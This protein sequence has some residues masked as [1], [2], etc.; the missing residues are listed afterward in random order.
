M[1][2]DYLLTF[3]GIPFVIDVARVIRLHQPVAEQE[4]ADQLPPRKYQPLVDLVDELDRMIPFRYLQEFGLQSEYPGRNIGAL[5]REER[6]ISQPLSNNLRIGDWYYPPTA[7]RW[8]VFRGLATS[9]QV[10]QMLQQ[11]GGSNA[12]TFVMQANP[13]APNHPDGDS[14]SY[15]L[16]S[17]MYMLPPRPLGEHGGTFD[18]LYLITLVDERYYWQN[19][20]ASIHPNQYSTWEG[21]ISQIANL[22]AVVVSHDPIPVVYGQPE[23]DSQLWTNAENTPALLDAIAFNV[24]MVAVR[25]LN[26]TYRLLTPRRSR[27]IVQQNRGDVNR[28]WRTAG[29]DLFNSGTKLPVGNLGAARNAVVPDFVNV[30]FPKYIRDDDPVPHFVNPRNQNQRPSAWYEESYGDCFVVSVP[31]A[32]GGFRA[33]GQLLSGSQQFSGSL[34]AG[35]VGNSDF[36]IHTTA[37]ALYSGEVFALSGSYP[38]SGCVP[39]NLSGLT[40]LAM[41]LA[42]DHYDGQAASALDEVY[43]GTFAWQPEGIH[44]IVWTC[45]ARIKQGSTRV[46]R[47][48]WNQVISEFQHSFVALSGSTN[49]PKGVGGPSVAQ[50]WKD[51]FSAYSGVINNRSDFVNSGQMYV[52]VQGV[53]HLPTQNRWR[54][55][56]DTENIL[57][58]GT[59]GGVT[60]SGF[61]SGTIQIG[62]VYR[63]IDGTIETSH[64]SSGVL[65]QTTPNAAYGANL[66][67][68][69]KMQFLHQ[70]AWTSG[71]IMETRIIPQTQ[72]V[73]SYSATGM[74]INGLIHYSGQL[75]TY[76]ATR[77]SGTAF[78][79]AENVWIIERNERPLL[80][81]RKYDGQIVG[82]AASGFAAPVYAVNE[83]GIFTIPPCNT[84]VDPLC[85]QFCIEGT[86]I[87]VYICGFGWI[88]L[89]ECPP[90]GS[91]A[92]SVVLCEPGECS[93]CTDPPEK[94]TIT[95][96]G[97][98]GDCDIF[99]AVWE[100]IWTGECIWQAA[101]SLEGGFG[102]VVTLTLDGGGHTLEFVGYNTNNSEISASFDSLAT[103]LPNCCSNLTFLAGA[104]DCTPSQGGDPGD[105]AECN[106]T[107][108]AYEMVITGGTGCY[109]R[110]N[111]TWYLTR[112]VRIPGGCG[113][114]AQQPGVNVTIQFL[115]RG[116]GSGLITV[117]DAM[118]RPEAA[119]NW[120]TA[121]FGPNCCT[122]LS[123]FTVDGG[124]CGFNEGTFPTLVSLDPVCTG[125]GAGGN[126]PPSLT[127]IPTCCSEVDPTG[128]ACECDECPDGSAP[129]WKFITPNANG[130]FEGY[131]NWTLDYDE[132]CTWSQ[133]QGGITATLS[134]N[135]DEDRW[136]LLFEHNNG[137]YWLMVEQVPFE[138]CSGN[139]FIYEDNDSI[140]IVEQIIYMEPFGPCTPCG[141]GSSG[142]TVFTDCCPSI[143]LPE[144]LHGTF[145]SGSG[146][147]VCMNGESVD[148]TWD[149][150]QY[151]GTFTAC[152]GG[153][154]TVTLTCSLLGWVLGMTGGVGSCVS[155]GGLVPSFTCLPLEMTT[156]PM[157][158]TGC[159]A[160]N[161]TL[162]ITD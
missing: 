154:T 20:P 78:V 126:C 141:D 31:I 58:E 84:V 16:T 104:C 100:L 142:G 131:L 103:G 22:L 95:A 24:G 118:Q 9:T 2:L 60:L 89:C 93:L 122:P 143:P 92:G 130:E 56:I 159:C 45:S 161:I 127:A 72:T 123:S 105:C 3:A 114:S 54:G 43:P 14:A 119:A 96:T 1:A 136:E 151:I 35:L 139:H 99:N 23:I 83:P 146:S 12:A 39:V 41:Q 111:G 64:G 55:V 75:Y 153:T 135:E 10:A 144:V 30:A 116:D 81:G 79:P 117:Y 112:D 11:T 19:T 94:W 7:S 150:L 21:L 120:V 133:T 98:T 69:E 149:G 148:L 57:F 85:N 6:T 34:V 68:A 5:A 160:G 152:S 74:S 42:T 88:F 82:Y 28:V 44:D 86:N 138:C 134:F 158:I 102:V 26:G 18:G 70:G 80:S 106:E 8:S 38:L 121:V 87:K 40:S 25:A 46:M 107:P 51:S 97:F 53:G 157:S 52:S 49:V 124:N 76:D 132:E 91:S 50:T 71:G 62:V 137:S 65:T 73:R 59:S 147:C 155:P 110:L 109:R 27:T 108:V 29:G 63:G 36:T 77:V 47:T 61:A 37:K 32:S 33:S 17:N 140:G 156:V 162:T 101:V 113:Y 48:E 15:T 90:P 145:H 128:P 129:Q 13:Y 4:A 66:I 125:S 67:T 115:I